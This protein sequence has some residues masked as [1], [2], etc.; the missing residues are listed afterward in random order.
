M[1]L[2][3]IGAGFGRTG[4]YSLKSALERLG[5]GPCHHM[6]EV[7][8]DPKQVRLWSEAADGRPDFARIFSSFRSA[9]DFPVAAF[10]PDA[11]AANPSARV[12]LSHRDPEDW[13]AS[14][15]QTIL[16]LILDKASWPDGARPWFKM[17]EKV[18]VGKALGGATDREGVLAA[19][20]ANVAAARDLEASG[21]TLVFDARDGWE[22]L[23]RF[24]SVEVP[25]EPYPK[26]NPRAE[27]FAAVKSG[28]EEPAT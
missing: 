26:T 10:W 7:I 8:G 11:L 6:S 12:I 2:D 4:T 20:R 27:F 22:P 3:I 25:D 15:S 18:I 9:V 19:Y 13:Y 21:Q 5:Y 28:T 17:I 14:F 24:L 1:A 23:C 16:P